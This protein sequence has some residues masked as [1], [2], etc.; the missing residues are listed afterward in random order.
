MAM[1]IVVVLVT[2]SIAAAVRRDPV[3]WDAPTRPA[4]IRLLAAA[5]LALW[6]A[7]V[8]CGRFIGYTWE[9]HV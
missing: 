6:V 8:C 2:R 5:S 3:R 7:I 1:I 9:F 4:S